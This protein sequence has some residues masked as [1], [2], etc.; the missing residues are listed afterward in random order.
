[1]AAFVCYFMT[2]L[3]PAGDTLVQIGQDIGECTRCALHKGRNKI[4]FG[5]GNVMLIVPVLLLRII[6]VI[7]WPHAE[8]ARKP[9]MPGDFRLYPEKRNS[10]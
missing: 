2:S 7:F 4:V 10:G 6:S 1:M 8:A 5:D 3:A 9:S